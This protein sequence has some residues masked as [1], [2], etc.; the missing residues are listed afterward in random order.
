QNP[1]QRTVDLDIQGMTCASCVNRVERKL[2]KLPGVTA[3][4]NLPLE[5]AKVTVPADISDEK[6]IE[7][8]KA[9]GYQA[10]VRQPQN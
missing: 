3:S 10:S 1:T 7:T 9:A 2:G 8:V 5:N 4:V 6:L